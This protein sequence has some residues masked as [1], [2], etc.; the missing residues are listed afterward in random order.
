MPDR[1]PRTLARVLALLLR[2]CRPGPGRHTGR[3]L[4]G[5]PEP[6][7][8][9]VPV[10]PWSRPWTGPTREEARATFQRQSE[11]T[12]QLRRSPHGEQRRLRALYYAPRGAG[13]PHVFRSAPLPADTIPTA[14]ATP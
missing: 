12:F 7:P 3:D 6:K 4:T 5:H 14:E 2:T 9:P 1:I 10:N 8:T 13:L 11:T